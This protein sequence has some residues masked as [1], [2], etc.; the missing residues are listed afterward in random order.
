[1]CIRTGD[2][3]TS[4]LKFY[5]S[6][7]QNTKRKFG[8]SVAG[9][10]YPDFT[11]GEIAPVTLTDGSET[12]FKFEGGYSY[13]PSYSI[14]NPNTKTDNWYILDIDTANRACGES[15]STF[16]KMYVGFDGTSVGN[17][18]AQWACNPDNRAGAHDIVATGGKIFGY[19]LDTHPLVGWEVCG[20]ATDKN[21]DAATFL[22]G[23]PADKPTKFACYPYPPAP[24]VNYPEYPP[25][26]YVSVEVPA[27]N[28]L[29]GGCNDFAGAA[30]IFDNG[31]TN[32]LVKIDASD[33]GCSE[34]PFGS[35]QVR[36]DM[37]IDFNNGQW[38]CNG[39]PDIQN[40]GG[41]IWVYTK[42][43]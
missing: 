42:S 9:G 34:D 7:P 15:P 35:V 30:I 20:E 25:M 19:Y 32:G 33:P 29:G 22:G 2:S 39:A 12:C 23:C 11:S 6:C 24:P 13:S 4:G 31:A 5:T 38:G 18:P 1:M 36:Q 40:T 21:T 28:Y 43:R 8:C 16:D 37:Y 10:D 26:Q 14:S 27:Y 17:N 3:T 41:K